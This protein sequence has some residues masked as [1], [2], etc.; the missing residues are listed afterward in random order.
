MPALTVSVVSFP[1]NRRVQPLGAKAEGESMVEIPKSRA[2]SP[3]LPPPQPAIFYG[4]VEPGNPVVDSFERDLGACLSFLRREREAKDSSRQ[5]ELH[6]RGATTLFNIWKNYKLRFPSWYYNEKLVKVGDQLVEMKEY[7][8]ALSQCYEQYLQEISSVNIN[9]LGFDVH[10]FKSFFFPSGFRDQTAAR[11]FHVLQVRNICIYK[12]VCDNDIDLLNQESVK[13]C[14]RILSTLQLIM[15]MILPHEHLCWLVYNGTIHM[16]TICR[17]L[18]TIGQS[19][20]VLEYLLWACVCMESSVPLLAVHYL[21]WRSTLYA[22]VCQCYYDCHSGMYGEIFA[23]RGLV[24]IDELKQMENMSSS[25]LSMETKKKFKEATV[26]MAA[27][28]F[29]RSAFEPRRR[30]K[31]LFRPRMK[32][33][34]KDSQH[35][36]WPRTITERLLM[37]MFDCN[38]SHF[39]AILEALFDR[40]RRTLIPS[41]PVPDEQEVRDVVSELFF[42]GMDILDGG[43]MNVQGSIPADVSCVITAKSTLMQ[44]ILAGKNGISGDAAL[45]FLKLAFSYEE[46]DYFDH[47]SVLF[48]SF[49]QSQSSPKWK[50]A[51]AELKLL[52]VMQPLVSIRRPRHGL[53]IQGNYLRETSVFRTPGKKSI[54]FQEGTVQTGKTTDELFMLA[55]TLYFCICTSKEVLLPDREMTIDATMFLWQ[56]CKVGIQRIQMSGSNFLKFIHKYQTPKWLHIL[57]I[58]NEV[59]HAINLGDTNTVVMAEVALRLTSVIENTADFTIKCG[60]TSVLTE[61]NDS[62][63]IS[64][65]SIDGMPSLIQKSPPEQLYLAFEYLDRAINAMNRAR[66]VI[67]LPDGASVIDYCCKKNLN[68]CDTNEKSV[69]GNNFIIDLHIELIQAQHRVAVKLLNLTQGIHTDGKNIKLKVAAKDI[70]QRK[71]LTEPDVMNKIKK[72]KLSRALFL[73]QKATLMLPVGLANSSPNQLLEEALIL[74]QKA[75]AEQNTLRAAFPQSASSVKSKVPPPPILLSRSHCSMAFKPAPFASDVKVSWYSIF[76]CVAK[77]CNPKVRLNHYNLK[78]T[79]EVVSFNETCILE[80]E[81]LEPNQKYIFAVAAYDSDGKLIGDCIGETTKPILAY[82]PLSAATVR[83]YLIQSAFQ[84]EYYALSKKAFQP[85]WDHFVSVQ[86]I[87]DAT[88]VFVSSTLAVPQNRLIPEALS[89]ASPNLLYLFIRSIFIISDISVIEGALF[90]DSVCFNELRYS[91]QVARIAECGRMLVALELSNWLNDVHYALQS[92]VHCYGLISPLVYHKIPSK[93]VIQIIIKFLTVLQEIPSITLQ[94]RSTACYESIQHM[95]ACSCFFTVKVLRSWKEYELAIVVVNYGKRLLDSSQTASQMAITGEGV[96]EVVEEETPSKRLRAQIAAAEKVNENLEALET[97]LLKLTKPG[98]DLTGEEDVLLLYPI[99]SNWQTKTAYKE[100][101]KFKKSPHF[102]EYF[103]K[104]VYK[105]LNEEKLIRILEWTDEVQD[106]LKKRNRFLLGIK[107]TAKKRR[108]GRTSAD[109]RKSATQD[110]RK[111]SAS[112][113]LKKIS[114][115]KISKKKEQTRHST[116]YQGVGRTSDLQRREKEESR[117]I[118]FQVLIQKLNLRSNVYIKRRRFRRVYTEEMPWRSQLN[119]YLAIVHFNLFKKRIEEL[120]NIDI[121]SLQ[122]LNSYH[123]LDPEI[124]SLIN[125]GTIVVTATTEEQMKTFKP[126]FFKRTLSGKIRK[127]NDTLDPTSPVFDSSPSMPASDPTLQSASS[128]AVSSLNLLDH[129]N[130]LT[131]ETDATMEPTDLTQ[132]SSSAAD[133]D[134]D[135]FFEHSIKMNEKDTPRLPQGYVTIKERERAQCYTAMLD[136]FAKIFLHFRR[137]VVFAHRG[138]HW[139]LLQNVC[140]DL[141]NYT[142]EVQS[143]IRHSQS[144]HEPFPITKE[145]FH[146]TIWLPYYM[147]SDMLLDMVVDLQASNSVKII[148]PEGDFCVPSCV[149]GIA[150]DEGGS[151]FS[152]E[153]PFDDINVVDLQGVHKLVLRTLELLFFLKKWESLIYIAMQFNTI[154]HERYTEQVTSLLVF[155]QRQLQERIQF[156]DSDSPQPC[157]KYLVTNRG[158]K[159]CCRD[160]V[161]IKLHAAA[162]CSE[163]TDEHDFDSSDM[164]Q[165]R[166][167]VSVPLDVADTLKCFSESL[168]KAKYH[169]R[170][171][172]YSRKLLALFLAYAQDYCGRL[173]ATTNQM[174]SHGRVE[175]MV[176]AELTYLPEPPDLSEE[177]FTCLS[178]VQSNSIPRSKLSVVIS[179]YERTLEVLQ[180]TNQQDLRVQAFHELGNLHSYTGNKRAAFKCWCQGLDGALKIVDALNHWQ[181]LHGLSENATGKLANI[182][183]GYCEKFVSQAGIWGCLQ[184]AV[185]AAKIAQHIL[186]YDVKLRTKACIL[187]AVLFKSLFRA[188]LPHPKADCDFVRYETDILIPGIDLFMDYYRADIATVV[189]SLKFVIYEL[190]CNKQNLIIL[191]LFTLYQY[192]VSEICRNAIKCIEGR[193]L[194]IKVL[195]DLGFFSDAF[196]ELCILNRGEKIPWKLPSIYKLTPKLPVSPTFDSSQ[197]LLTNMNLQALEDVFNRPIHSAWTALCEP[198]ILDEFMLVK[199]HFIICLSATLNCVPE[200]VMK[201]TYCLDSETLRKSGKNTDAYLKGFVTIPASGKRDTIFMIVELEKNKDTLTMAILKGILLAEAEERINLIL[202][203]VQNKY[204]T[205][206][207]ECSAAELETVIEAKL[208]LAAIAQQRLQTAFSAA[209]AFSAIKL[210]QDATVFKTSSN[211]PQNTVKIDQASDESI[212]IEDSNLPHNVIARKRMNIHLWLRCRLALVTAVIAQAR[213]IETMKENELKECSCLISEVQMEAEAFNDVET[214]AEITM[215]AVML[216]LQEGQPVADIKI[217]LQNIIRL[218]EEK[219]LISP[220]A[221]LTLVQSMLLLADI[222]RTQAGD[223]SNDHTSKTD[224]LNLLITAHTLVIQQLFILGQLLEQRT[225]D[226]TLTTLM[227]PLKNIYL[228]HIRLLAKV[229]LRIGHTLTLELSCTSKPQSE[230]QWLKALKH[231]ETAL[232][233][234]ASSV[235]RE[236][237]LEAELLFRKGKIERQ[238]DCLGGNKS[239]VAVESLLDAVNLSLSSYQNY[240]LIRKSYMEVALLYFYLITN[241]EESPTSGTL[242]GRTF[243]PRPASRHRV[244]S[245]EITAL[246]MYRVQA[247]IAIRAAAQVS[248][249]ILTSQQLIGKKAVKLYQVRHRILQNMPEFALLD[250]SSSYKDFLSEGYEVCYKVPVMS[251]AQEDKSES[252]GAESATSEESQ[253]KL[254]IPWVHVIRYNTYLTRHLNLSPLFAIPKAGEGL[255]A[256]EDVLFT[257]VF[258]TTVT[259]RLAQLHSFLK[260]YLPI[261]TGCCLQ[262]PPKQLYDFEKPCFSMTVLG[263]STT[264]SLIVSPHRIPSW[265][266]PSSVTCSSEMDIHSDNKATSTPIRELCVQWYLP[267]LE[268]SSKEGETM[269]LF[270]FAYNT[271][272][273]KIT[274]IKSFNS[275]NVYCGYLWIPLN[276]VIGVRE[277]LSDLKLQIEMLMQT[278]KTSQA[279]RETQRHLPSTGSIKSTAKVP[280]DEKT[281]EMVK[282]CFSEIKALLSVGPNQPPPLTEIPFDITLPAIKN[283][284]KLFEPANGCVIIAGSVFNWIVSL[285][286]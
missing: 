263:K 228:P 101:L 260:A 17:H 242:K 80:V 88:V 213:G 13:T 69:I 227:E 78:N 164:N 114:K 11:T 268:R 64:E 237:D 29:K 34:L 245:E 255:F 197:L 37:E 175:F 272:A 155:A 163:T 184:G 128:D 284:R 151:N 109:A 115:P 229:K 171:L 35:L 152:F 58:I 194:K 49:L 18:M 46:W 27:M 211:L 139:T 25:A 277:K 16:Y 280:L 231:I 95:I 55:R 158:S 81:D 9:K 97:N 230:F 161:A 162:K 50:E 253:G 138:G 276:S 226:P 208:Q 264:E 28:I 31:G 124:F 12:M 218:L 165:G 45:R 170:S 96:D 270:I 207:Y 145:F 167:R 244:S 261:Y 4:P 87:P 132:L 185:L 189:A 131:P 238:I 14:F 93:P 172:K 89:R 47:V 72:N 246:E 248:E 52:L 105:A 22:A 56:R 53:C 116:K 15:Q 210:L 61:K 196:H 106:Y 41:P 100:V 177:S 120:Y 282:Q 204:G 147:A 188:S 43:G 251:F 66:Q 33:N 7:K 234:C 274:N 186:L 86:L 103:V 250:L 216:G 129:S 136:N 173:D 195:T 157:F 266:V 279:E 111:M 48:F 265:K 126:P 154:T 222:M 54:A 42:A 219:T 143:I 215:Q 76:G 40:N 108:K 178:L 77:G 83:A 241:K 146:D 271:K 198:R 275:A 59:I 214:L 90:C 212:Y 239:I 70:N 159:V 32:A 121:N 6:R 281:K 8:L 26:K 257:S 113:T 92:V 79:A 57:Y 91:R 190:H 199:M 258:D 224:Q 286:A 142:Q 84:I 247:W 73:M 75:E 223:D 74:I 140:R 192:F 104:L 20:K 2:L 156:S 169:S 205:L 182:S 130:C 149:G 36:P 225:E 133:S 39:F 85:L 1:S 181:E 240:G 144:F 203:I 273:V 269:V 243:K 63:L 125:S 153:Y 233:L 30:P 183:L 122:N 150:D 209:L 135:V 38:S 179:S 256:K 206:L 112:P 249:A 19:S 217:C 99:V 160:F 278:V 62:V 180:T 24:K 283:L 23:R 174:S 60:T 98:Q 220:P 110:V 148:E 166:T 187:S 232:D 141:W 252:D 123:E 118:A 21:T 221:S 44:Q 65:Y 267:S 107:R 10:Q 94:R 102:L 5:Q 134:P 200:K 176:G 3:T 193:I 127:K 117:K 262:E 235:R 201:A 137:A 68:K 285:L 82:S 71:H 191:P 202:E 119:L 51:E 168:E 254:K 236:L 259:L 67:L